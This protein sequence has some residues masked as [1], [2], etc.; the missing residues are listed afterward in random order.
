[1]SSFLCLPQQSFI[2]TQASTLKILWRNIMKKSI[3]I[4]HTLSCQIWFKGTRFDWRSLTQLGKSLIHCSQVHI[5]FN[6]QDFKVVLVAMV[7]PYHPQQLIFTLQK[8]LSK[9]VGQN[10]KGFPRH[11]LVLWARVLKFK[12][13]HL[14]HFF[15][16]FEWT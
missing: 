3:I 11:F 7:Y 14:S 13:V 15:G 1:M 8:Y 9:E 10:C 12:G 5:S 6:Y 2:E 4:H 16:I